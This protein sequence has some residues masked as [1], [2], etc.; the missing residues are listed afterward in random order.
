MLH[1][2]HKARKTVGSPDSAPNKGTTLYM[3]CDID[4]LSDYQCLVRKNI[5]IFVAG[6]SELDSTAKGR[7]KPIMHGQVGIRCLHCAWLDPRERKKGAMYYPAKLSGI[8]QAAQSLASSHLCNHC[9]HVPPDIRKQLHIL[10]ERKSSA[11]GGK[12]YWSDSARI[13][14]VC[15]DPE[16][17]LYYKSRKG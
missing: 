16:R 15:E 6:A 7:N 11:G 10:K 4:N 8:Y 5:E 3:K 14:G 2:G 9:E 12:D 17:G 1:D 13:I